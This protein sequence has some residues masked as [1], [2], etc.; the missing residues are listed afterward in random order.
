M[1]WVSVVEYTRVSSVASPRPNMNTS[2]TSSPVDVDLTNA[3]TESIRENTTAQ[4]EMFL[5]SNQSTGTPS[6]NRI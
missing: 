5:K 3:F 4:T 1:V 6:S 2:S